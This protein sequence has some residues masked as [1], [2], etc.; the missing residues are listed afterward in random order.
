MVDQRIRPRVVF[1]AIGLFDQG[2][3]R[4]LGVCIHEAADTSVDRIADEAV[5]I[6]AGQVLRGPARHLPVQGRRSEGFAGLN[7]TTA[8]AGRPLCTMISTGC[9]PS[10][11][12]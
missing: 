3:Q 1:V 8:N 6:Q 2:Q 10:G 7:Q 12:V 4:P 5:V 9:R 11:A